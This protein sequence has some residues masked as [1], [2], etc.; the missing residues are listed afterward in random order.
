[1]RNQILY[2][3]FALLIFYSCRGNSSPDTTSTGTEIASVNS[4]LE[5]SD[6]YQEVTIDSKK[7]NYNESENVKSLD[8]TYAN[9]VYQFRFLE[10]KTFLKINNQENQL[11][12]WTPIQFNSYY[13]M[14]LPTAEKSVYLLASGK[15]N[16]V[17]Y[18]ILPAFT[19]EFPTYFLY[20][21]DGEN[22]HFKGSY[23]SNHEVGR[24]F[25]YDETKQELAHTVSGKKTPLRFV[26]NRVDLPDFSEE[27]LK[28]LQVNS[29]TNQSVQL[30][31][32]IHSKTFLV[33]EFDLN[34]DG[35]KDKILSHLPY[36]GDQLFV[37][38]GEK[39]STNFKL[40]L[41]TTNFS[42]DGGNQVTDVRPT[43]TGFE[44]ITDFPDRGK[45]QFT[46]QIDFNNNRFW[47]VK[48]TTESYSHQNQT[49]ETC[50]K[51]LQVDLS[52]EASKIYNAIENSKPKCEKEKS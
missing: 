19:E 41:E 28:K 51:N 37:F 34:K 6:V 22:L 30:E 25:M 8:L 40:A 33:K 42:E 26:S 24:N 46:Y 16:S 10:D 38:L 15:K 43:K 21:F 20:H 12:D 23:E 7:S 44:V 49:T 50:V 36:Q 17:V 3:I 1:M 52:S 48:L 31:N 29:S 13:D 35:V 27:D 47:L 5:N 45:Y 32:L 2:P 39:N 11:L 18:F 4:G 14:D 9:S